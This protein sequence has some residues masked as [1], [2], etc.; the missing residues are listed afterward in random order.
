MRSYG[1]PIKS[2]NKAINTFGDSGFCSEEVSGIDTF[3]SRS[4]Y[5][6]V[7]DIPKNVDDVI[8]NDILSPMFLAT[9][10]ITV[11]DG[12]EGDSSESSTE[13]NDGDVVYT[14][15]VNDFYKYVKYTNYKF[16]DKIEM[17]TPT[18]KKETVNV[19]G[20]TKNPY[21][22]F[23]D[24]YSTSKKDTLTVSEAS[25]ITY[26]SA[27]TDSLEIVYSGKADPNASNSS[28]GL[29][30]VKIT[31]SYNEYILY[32]MNF[33]SSYISNIQGLPNGVIYDKDDNTIK[34]KSKYQGTFYCNINLLNGD[35]VDLELEISPIQ[36]KY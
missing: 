7:Y 18:T 24:P 2:I 27:Y 19:S 33:A 9:N 12:S 15:D 34:G 1:S 20:Y 10:S 13:N 32:S 16:K 4:D 26:P 14:Y 31:A 6:T 21:N 25:V 22:Y 29:D 8:F 3:K 35:T 36:R 5:L 30:R 23:F 11:T 17:I 28:T